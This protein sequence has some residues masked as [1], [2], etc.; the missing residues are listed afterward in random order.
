MHGWDEELKLCGGPVK[1]DPLQYIV[2]GTLYIKY[3]HAKANQNAKK[4]VSKISWEDR[5]GSGLPSGQVDPSRYYI[6]EDGPDTVRYF[7]RGYICAIF[8]RLQYGYPS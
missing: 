7:M 6:W 4:I 1:D 5:L 3:S 2:L 8:D